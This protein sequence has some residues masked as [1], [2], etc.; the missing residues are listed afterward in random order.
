MSESDSASECE[1]D[2]YQ[3]VYDMIREQTLKGIADEELRARIEA[4]PDNRALFECIIHY[5]DK[6]CD[7][8][9]AYMAL[10]K[11]IKRQERR[12]EQIQKQMH[13]HRKRIVFKKIEK[14]ADQILNAPKLEIKKV[15]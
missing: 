7:W 4:N 10:H 1:C 8:K 13:K 9:N 12:E 5:H 6:A 11:K 15:H 14:N 2:I 3:I